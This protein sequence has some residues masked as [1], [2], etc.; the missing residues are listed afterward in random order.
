MWPLI[1]VAW[2]GFFMWTC[3]EAGLFQGVGHFRIT[4]LGIRL[5][6]V[7]LGT[8]VWIALVACIL[9]F[10]GIRMDRALQAVRYSNV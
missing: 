9:A 5:N 3:G 4:I 7:I 2:V 8:I 1:L 10:W 6:E